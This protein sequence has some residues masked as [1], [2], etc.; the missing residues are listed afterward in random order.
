LERSFEGIVRTVS[1]RVDLVTRAVTVRAHIDNDDRALRP[2]MLLTVR[3]VMAERDALVVDEGAVFELAN[4]AYLFTVDGDLTAHRRAID[5]G[6]RRFGR[7]EVLGGLSEGEQVVVEGTIKL[8]DGLRVRL[9]NSD[10]EVS[11]TVPDDTDEAVQP[12]RI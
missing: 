1:S 6:E 11:S 8:R 10:P 2:W 5:I 12:A 9:A 4:Q 7:V 3:V